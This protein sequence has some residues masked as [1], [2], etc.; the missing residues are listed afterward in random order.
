MSLRDAI[1]SILNQSQNPQDAINFVPNQGMLKQGN[2]D[3]HNRPRYVNPDG[4]IS[5]VRSAGV[6]I[7]DKEMLLPT[8]GGTKENPQSLTL[9][10]AV[11]LYLKTRQNLGEFYNPRMS[12]IYAN[13]LHQSQEKEYR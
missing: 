11:E 4:S 9:D 3:L 13:E 2:I 5:T 1:S 8:I 10:E 12:N 6:N 7:G